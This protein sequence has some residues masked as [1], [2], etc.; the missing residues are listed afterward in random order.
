MKR[1]KQKT[2]PHTGNP[3]YHVLWNYEIKSRNGTEN[4][5]DI[6][7]LG[8]L[9]KGTAVRNFVVTKQT[10][11]DIND[12]LCSTTGNFQLS[13]ASLMHWQGVLKS[14]LLK[15]ASPHDEISKHPQDKPVSPQNNLYR[16]DYW[17]Q[18]KLMW[19]DISRKSQELVSISSHFSKLVNTFDYM[20]HSDILSLEN[21]PPAHLVS[22]SVSCGLLQFAL[23][24]H[25]TMWPTS[26]CSCLP[27]DP[28]DATLP[29][30][31]HNEIW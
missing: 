27:R 1:Y 19:H 14:S 7:Y 26:E 6:W 12:F 16:T 24:T 23:V 30:N 31:A 10:T 17:T 8:L 22:L 9:P 18:T 2:F 13:G 29:N 5:S 15:N 20:K 21:A 11:K 28:G 4:N 3:L 25:L